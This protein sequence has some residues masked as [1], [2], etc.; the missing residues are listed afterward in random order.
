MAERYGQLPSSV[1]GLAP[2]SW[3][4]FAFDMA[5]S[6]LADRVEEAVDAA[7][8]K[9]LKSSAPVARERV[10]HALG[11]VLTT[12]A[13]RDAEER[14]R[15]KVSGRRVELV[16]EHGPNDPSGLRVITHEEG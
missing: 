13:E 1:L 14:W 9:S 2:G 11:K 6:S 12:Q 3:S 10:R 15:E 16:W 4:A 7:R 8:E 5:V